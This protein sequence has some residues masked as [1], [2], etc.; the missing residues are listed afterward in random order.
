M[1][2]VRRRSSIF[3]DFITPP[4]FKKTPLFRCILQSQTFSK[5]VVE[6]VANDILKSIL[7]HKPEIAQN[8]IEEWR[9]LVAEYQRTE[10]GCAGTIE[11]SAAVLVR[12]G[13]MEA[14]GMRTRQR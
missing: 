9:E 10:R 7:V 1:S 12:G 5:D 8:I 14:P 6:L 13:Q 11:T 2:S 4:D 3:E